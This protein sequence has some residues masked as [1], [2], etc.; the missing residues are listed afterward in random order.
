MEGAGKS[1]HV[2]ME[3]AGPESRGIAGEWVERWREIKVR[4]G[5]KAKKQ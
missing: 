1:G 3:V 5:Q 4:R 2:E